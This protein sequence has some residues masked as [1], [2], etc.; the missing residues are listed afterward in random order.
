MSAYLGIAA[1]ASNFVWIGY[2]VRDYP[3]CNT[4]AVDGS[5]ITYS[6]IKIYLT[7]RRTGGRITNRMANEMETLSKSCR[8]TNTFQFRGFV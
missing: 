7:V 8:V 4:V 6:Y 3:T 1:S 2:Q 5:A